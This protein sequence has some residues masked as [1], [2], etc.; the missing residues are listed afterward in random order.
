VSAKSYADRPLSRIQFWLILGAM[1]VSG[2]LALV[3]LGSV[4]GKHGTCP[5]E[6]QISRP[7]AS[8]CWAAYDNQIHHGVVGHAAAS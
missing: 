8:S 2:V 3:V 6:T 4:A 5:T 7:G 1:A